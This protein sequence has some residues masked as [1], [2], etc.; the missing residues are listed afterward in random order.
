MPGFRRLKPEGSHPVNIQDG[1]LCRAESFKPGPVGIEPFGPNSPKCK[2][3]ILGF[4]GAKVH[5]FL[6]HVA[7]AEMQGMRVNSRTA[8]QI[9]VPKARALDGASVLYDGFLD[10]CSNGPNQAT[11]FL[12]RQYDL[13]RNYL[14]QQV[15]LSELAFGAQVVKSAAVVGVAIS[16]LFLAGP[17]LVAGAGIG[18]RVR[19]KYGACQTA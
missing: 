17:E 6:L 8:A 11:A 1:T 7:L 2:L 18:P 10:A 5:D 19:R 16:G 3:R 13:Q 9:P 12:A 4:N 14:R 15:L